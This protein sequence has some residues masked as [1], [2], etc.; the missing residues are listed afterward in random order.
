MEFTTNERGTNRGLNIQPPNDP[1]K[2]QLN[3]TLIE[4][5]YRDI[6]HLFNKSKS[7][8]SGLIGKA[9]EVFKNFKNT[10]LNQ[11]LSKSRYAEAFL[12]IYSFLLDQEK[13]ARRDKD[14]ALLFAYE[15][16]ETD[17]SKPGS[18]TTKLV[19][20]PWTPAR[21]KSVK[22]FD[23][24]KED[25][26]KQCF[27]YSR[28]FQPASPGQFVPQKIPVAA[29]DVPHPGLPAIKDI[30]AEGETYEEQ[31]IMVKYGITENLKEIVRQNQPDPVLRL[32]DL[33]LAIRELS[34]HKLNMNEARQIASEYLNKYVDLPQNSWKKDLLRRNY[35]EI[36]K[37]VNA[38]TDL[39]V[40]MPIEF[41]FSNY[42]A[43]NL[44][45]EFHIDFGEDFFKV[46][47]G[48]LR[49]EMNGLYHLHKIDNSLKIFFET[50]SRKDLAEVIRCV[51]T[52]R[53]LMVSYLGDEFQD[54]GKKR[55]SLV[56]RAF[57]AALLDNEF[58]KAD[59]QFFLQMD[60]TYF[61]ILQYIREDKLELAVAANKEVL[62]KLN[63]VRSRISAYERDKL[64]WGGRI[65][66]LLTLALDVLI[67]YVTG[68]IGKFLPR[69][70]YVIKAMLPLI[71]QEIHILSGV[72]D[73]RMGGMEMLKEF[74]MGMISQRVANTVTH[75]FKEVFKVEINRFNKLVYD[76]VLNNFVAAFQEELIH[77][78]GKSASL[79]D[80]VE[81]LLKNMV[82]GIA[83]DTA[84]GK[85]IERSRPALEIRIKTNDASLLAQPKRVAEPGI[86]NKLSSEPHEAAA[87]LI[88]DTATA[89]GHSDLKTKIEF[90]I[91][92]GKND[93]GISPKPNQAERAL[94][95]KKK[96]KH[97]KSGEEG[98]DD[99][100]TVSRRE[101]G[102]AAKGGSKGGSKKKK[103]NAVE[104]PVAQPE[105]KI[106]LPI[107]INTTRSGFRRQLI[108]FFQKN[109]KH[110]LIALYDKPNN[111]LHPSTK[112]GMDEFYWHENPQ[113]IQ[114]G[115]VDSHK[116]ELPEK[117]II[118][119]AWE[120]QMLK[121]II[122]G[123]GTPAYMRVRR[124]LLI[125]GLPITEESAKHL[126]AFG[127]LEQ[128]HLD[129]AELVDIFDL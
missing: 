4:A 99:R 112:K 88:E 81:N 26:I 76:T 125:D 57:E 84:A 5:V 124:V 47:S 42:S 39:K 28:K 59:K 44:Y 53:Y 49:R 32:E 27:D 10:N 86:D 90:D 67:S 56:F 1:G 71:Q 63:Q 126:V 69:A 95:P 106:I 41:V 127:K 85:A 12:K 38:V 66:F 61:R 19:D 105:Q 33:A 22:E 110:P 37:T 64:K 87:T 8:I 40:E 93:K 20:Q 119:T 104:Q 58:P 2:D 65:L 113:A 14:G 17:P 118:M 83:H 25:N 116:S 117:I 6:A 77:L 80:F 109:P 73:K 15:K 92:S 48:K 29:K 13:K 128:E 51:A 89:T 129:R 45:F 115:H 18:Y 55:D 3:A 68:A 122:E 101:S 62:E 114:A 70:N 43:I 120:N 78:A 121:S 23:V 82:S 35:A 96:N 9:E 91:E 102:N 75:K 98:P 79:D 60:D 21:Q 74:G 7:S 97:G 52:S 31:V 54:L 24:F 72:Q 100:T 46:I 111:R 103:A 123:K 36:R 11:P 50:N 108:E 107:L 34:R 94:P 16:W 30:V